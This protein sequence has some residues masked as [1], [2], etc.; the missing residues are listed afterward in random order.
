MPG[1]STSPTIGYFRCRRSSR[2]ST[3]SQN[4]A[5]REDDDFAD[6]VLQESTGKALSVVARGFEVGARHRLRLGGVDQQ[7]LF[8]VAV[9]ALVFD[10]P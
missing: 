2:R 5:A 7:A 4:A 1:S 6:L 8:R 3:R 10:R 9:L